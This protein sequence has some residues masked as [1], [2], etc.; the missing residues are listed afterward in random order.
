MPQSKYIVNPY[1]MNDDDDE[2]EEP[3]EDKKATTKSIEGVEE[4][5]GIQ[6]ERISQA[7]LLRLQGSK[8]LLLL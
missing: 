7:L 2:R 8:P 1:L 4:A 3:K 6:P 5:V